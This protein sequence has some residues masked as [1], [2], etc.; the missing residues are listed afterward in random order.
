M[1]PSNS[2]LTH[3]HTHERLTMKRKLVQYGDLEGDDASIAAATHASGQNSISDRIS[4]SQQNRD[5]TKES[6]PNRPNKKKKKHGQAGPGDLNE[7]EDSTSDKSLNMLMDAMS[8]VMSSV[9]KPYLVKQLGEE[10]YE[11]CLGLQSILSKRSNQRKR[12]NASKTQM[13]NE[14]LPKLSDI[15]SP[16][17]LTPWTASH[18]PTTIPP[19]P[20]IL[21]PVLEKEA[22]THR[23]RDNILNYERLE[24]I[25]D[26]YIE[27]I[28]TL[29]IASTFSGLPIGRLSQLRERLVKNE[30]LAK[31]SNEYGFMKQA[32]LQSDFHCVGKKEAM[33]MSGDIFEA[34]CAAIVFSDPKNGVNRLANWL[35][36]LFARTLSDDILALKP[37][38]S[39][40]KFPNPRN[41]SPKELLA[42]SLHSKGTKMKLQYQDA[43]PETKAAHISG[44][45][46]F[47]IGVYL[48][49]WG[50]EGKLLGVGKG[51]SKK[52]A[53][54][55][56]AE[57]ALANKDVWKLYETKK[58]A[59]ARN[60]AEDANAADPTPPDSSAEKS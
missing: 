13:Q 5:H 34:Y 50:H 25:G 29:L 2:Q 40:F 7:A 1:A 59:D 52:E 18:I 60:A 23:S 10:G 30:N 47:T 48:D 14:A 57:A 17:M 51:L 4:Q 9:S 42:L 15:P 21:D 20:D 28:S 46:V 31:Y 24:W 12:N 41:L 54:S 19:L 16:T 53:G 8:D 58:E 3:T 27:L 38:E 55:R 49:G 45:P 43:A 33:K 22:F 39:Q 56:A 32:H 44:H 37:R 6:D 26:I 36:A 11:Q 35:K